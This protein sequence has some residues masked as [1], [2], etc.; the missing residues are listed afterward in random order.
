MSISIRILP[1]GVCKAYMF[2]RPPDYRAVK[3]DNCKVIRRCDDCIAVN[4]CISNL[5]P[6]KCN[7]ECGCINTFK[8]FKDDK[9]TFGKYKG[10]SLE[11]VYKHNFEY[12]VWLINNNK[13]NKCME[14]F[15]N[16]VKDNR[17]IHVDA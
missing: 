10:M 3:F 15:L 13:N 1:C 16:H 7:D 14:D 6:K 9:I 4:E 11:Y 5:F 8:S 2:Q 12:L 17:F